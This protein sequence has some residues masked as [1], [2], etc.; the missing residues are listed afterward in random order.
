[1]SV[2]TSEIAPQADLPVLSSS[3]RRLLQAPPVK[4]ESLDRQGASEYLVV[5]AS[6]PDQI[7]ICE[8]AVARM[9]ER[10][11]IPINRTTVAAELF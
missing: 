1:M 2:A 11:V 4:R 9:R 6:G 10:G 3:L 8:N 5:D 7:A